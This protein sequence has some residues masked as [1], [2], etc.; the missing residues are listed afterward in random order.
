MRWVGAA[1]ILFVMQLLVRFE[2]AAHLAHPGE[3]F[4]VG[5][6]PFMGS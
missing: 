3:T 2:I 4:R 5:W 1:A 6:L